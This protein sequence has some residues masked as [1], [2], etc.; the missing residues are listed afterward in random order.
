MN[1]L[2]LHYGHSGSITISKDNELIVHTELERFSK[3]KYGA[4][5][6]L[7]LIEKINELNICFDLIVL[8]I[9]H[10]ADI[11]DI[12]F[13]L[14]NKGKNCKIIVEDQFQT[15]HHIYH[16]YCAAYNID[17]EFDYIV[18]LD[19]NGKFNKNLEEEKVSIYDN[20]FNEVY[21]EYYTGDVSLGWAYQIVNL[22]LYQQTFPCGKTM[23]LSC[24]GSYDNNIEI[25]KDNKF[26]KQ[27]FK[28]NLG[29]SEGDFL[30]AAEWIPGLSDSKDNKKAL[31]FVHTF[32]KGCEEYCFNLFKRFNNKKILFT[33]GVAQNVLINTLLNEK[34]SNTIYVDPMSA[35]HGISLGM[36]VFYTNNKLKKK[37]DYYLG[38]K[39]KYDLLNKLFNKHNIKESNEEEVA[40]L[41]MQDP[42][43]IF[44][45]GSEQGQRGLGNRSLLMNAE[46]KNCLE[47]INKIKKREWY[48]PFACS[49]L[50]EDLEEW[51]EID[52]KKEPYYMMFV[53]KAKKKVNNIVSVENTCRLQAVKKEH[54]KN[55]YNLIKEFKKQTKFPYVLNTSLNLPGYTLVEDLFD[56]CYIFENSDLKYIWLPEIK[57]VII[58]HGH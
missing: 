4:N 41:L 13:S 26:N 43:A 5:F 21:K 34:T 18:V 51:F 20:K 8:S 15:K 16:A 37:H 56:L 29:R 57:K 33:G 53:Y 10:P 55:Y 44:Q 48:R 32:Q 11:K 19:G 50:H 12:I 25:L 54:N 3:I 58:K 6:T 1:I 38:F 22:A 2:T 28:K 17:K 39:P 40:R 35:D 14:I 52:N 49:I 46:H 7:N 9:W 45:G 36:N 31:N 42:V 27:Y 47:K 23:A 30:T 24:Y